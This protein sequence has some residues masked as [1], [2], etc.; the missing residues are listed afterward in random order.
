V[1][2]VTLP[3]LSGACRVELNLNGLG[4]RSMVAIGRV[5]HIAASIAPEAQTRVYWTMVWVHEEA[6]HA[7]A[8]PIAN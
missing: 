5:R 1:L 7:Q 4:V 3:G 2:D 6:C 8:A